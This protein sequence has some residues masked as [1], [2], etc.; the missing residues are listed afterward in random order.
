MHRVGA[1]ASPST[2]ALYVAPA[3]AAPRFGRQRR[4]RYDGRRGGLA[5]VRERNIELV[6]IGPEAPL[7][8]GVADVLR[9][10]ASVFGPNADGAQLE[11]SKS[12]S[13]EFMLNNGIP[14]AAYAVFDDE[15]RFGLRARAGAPIVIKADGLAAGKGVVVAETVEDAEA[16]VRACFE[17]AFGDAGST[18]VVEECMTGPECSL[19]CFVTGGQ[20]F[21]MAPAQ[22]HKRAYDG[23]MG[24]NTGGMGV[25]SRCP[26]SPTRRCTTWCASW[27]MPPRDRARAVRLDYRGTLYGGFMLTP[28]GRRSSSSTRASAIRKLRWFCLAWRATSSTSCWRWRRGRPEDIELSWSDTW[29]VCVVLASEGYPGLTRRA[30]SFSA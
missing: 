10:A 19:L 21:P 2:D 15:A 22:D 11:G 16:A 3:T 24:P 18:V 14:T 7:V 8:K 4:R 20:S 5:F 28:A 1:A 13:K 26:S 27:R 23:D 30:R 17:G 29:A 25:Y 12:Y 9:E 6:V